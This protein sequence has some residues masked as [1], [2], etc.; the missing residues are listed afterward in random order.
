MN[1]DTQLAEFCGVRGA[2]KCVISSPVP[3][4]CRS[5][6]CM[7][8]ID[9][10]GRGPV[11]GPMV[12]GCA[13]CPVSRLNRLKQLGCADSKTLSAEAREQLFAKLRSARP[14]VTEAECNGGGSKPASSGRKR[15]RPPTKRTANTPATNTDADELEQKRRKGEEEVRGKG[16]QESNGNHPEDDTSCS[17]VDAPAADSDSSKVQADDATEDIDGDS[18]KDNGDSDVEK[19]H[20]GDSGEVKEDTGDSGKVKNDTGD[21]GEVKEEDDESAEDR[22]IGWQVELLSPSFISQNMFKR[23][24]YN[25]NWLSHDCAIALIERCLADGVNVTEVYVDTVGPPEK[26]QAKLQSRFPH[27]QFTVAKKADSLYPTVSAASICAKVLRDRALASWKCPENPDIDVSQLGSG[28]PADPVTKKFLHDNL[29]PVFGF[30]SVVRFSWATCKSIME[31][32]AVQTTW[33]E[34]TEG[35]ETKSRPISSFFGGSSQCNRHVF[36]TDRCLRE[37][38]PL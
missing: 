3:S 19:K 31:S 28:Y 1:I 36:F 2:G 24:K 23:A 13:Y 35:E 14:S 11:L 18:S 32:S 4:L 10:A 22:Y 20:R 8:G 16:E 33:E 26:Y 12:Y 5:E 25:L 9:E 17:S 34:E 30:P 38:P 21:S 6:P 29:D 15:G 7:L 37:A 27:I